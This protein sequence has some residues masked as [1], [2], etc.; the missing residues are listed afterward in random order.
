MVATT[1]TP[2]PDTADDDGLVR[3]EFIWAVLDCPT[4]FALY[5]GRETL[6]VSFLARQ[7]S[8]HRP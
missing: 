8:A 4:Y 7:T 2:T 6:P 1:W 5:A 3:P